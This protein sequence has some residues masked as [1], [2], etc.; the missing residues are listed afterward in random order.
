[1]IKQM[2]TMQI[3]KTAEKIVQELF[4]EA[5]FEVIKY[6]YEHTVPKLANKEIKIIGETA[7]YIRHQPDFIVVN[8]KNEAF[9][10]EVKF[11]SGGVIKKEHMFNYPS[12]YVVFLTTEFILGQRLDKIY[13]YGDNF[14]MLNSLNP[15]RQISSKLIVKYVDKT[16]R[17]LGD[18]TLF[19]QWSTKIIERITKRKLRIPKKLNADIEGRSLTITGWERLEIIPDWVTKKIKT[20]KAK[21]I[22]EGYEVNGEHYRY[23]V[24]EVY[25]GKRRGFRK[26]K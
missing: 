3:G 2:D 4:E 10:V 17:K 8:K 21:K 20:R 23:R 19:G 9:F 15:F 25:D 16:R 14:E 26:K 22:K 5:G 18:E 12:C 6:G 13:K 11:R 7:D 1:M 24:I